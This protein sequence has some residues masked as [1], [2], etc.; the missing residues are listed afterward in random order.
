MSLTGI[1]MPE[2]R[3]WGGG[4]QL[5]LGTKPLAVATGVGFVDGWA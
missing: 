1:I 3:C 4:A 5:F 2:T